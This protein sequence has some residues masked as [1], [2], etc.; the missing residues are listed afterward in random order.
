MAYNEW[1]RLFHKIQSTV[2]TADNLKAVY[3][4]KQL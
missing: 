4:S 1:I 3:I 2:P